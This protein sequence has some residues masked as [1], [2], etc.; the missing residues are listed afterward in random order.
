ML[1][2][3]CRLELLRI[4]AQFAQ[5]GCQAFGTLAFLFGCLLRLLGT[6]FGL[7]DLLLCPCGA[8]GTGEQ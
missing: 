8:L 7:L 1:P 4:N 5:L 3:P 2:G 6:L